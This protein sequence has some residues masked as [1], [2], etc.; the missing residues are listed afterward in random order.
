MIKI[1]DFCVCHVFRVIR[2]KDPTSAFDKACIYIAMN[3]VILIELPIYLEVTSYSDTL[4]HE[5][6]ESKIGYMVV[7]IFFGCILKY[8]LMRYYGSKKRMSKLLWRYRFKKGSVFWGVLIMFAPI[9]LLAGLTV[10][11]ALLQFV[12]E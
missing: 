12:V 8:I 9:W 7:T 6:Y 4:I 2:K 11:V 1:L 5:I 10:Y 3:L